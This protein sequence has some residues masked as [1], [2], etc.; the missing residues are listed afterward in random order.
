MTYTELENK[1]ID[2]IKNQ[3][4]LR[5]SRS[6]Q[7]FLFSCYTGLDTARYL[8]IRHEQAV[9]EIENKILQSIPRLID[10]I[11]VQ[12]ITG[13]TWFCGLELSVSPGVL[14]PRPETEELVSKIIESHRNSSGRQILDIGTGSGAI[15]VALSYYLQ[16]AE[17]YALDISGQALE[18]AKANAEIHRQPVRFL[19]INILDKIQT[20]TLQQFD[21]IVSNPPYVKESERM[22]MQSNVLD[23]EPGEA[24]FV[25]DDN[26]LIFYRAITEFARCHLLPGGELWFEFNESEAD[27]LVEVLELSGFREIVVFQDLHN[28]PRFLSCL[29]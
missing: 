3:Y 5:E 2:A 13:K 26:P 21:I 29:L 1:V 15:A 23:H 8:L 17:V 14:I 22:Y 10:Y 20:E 12:Y 9:P 18:L 25:P 28:K 27:K 6:I 11:P 4:G 16:K 19:E 7:K 24:L